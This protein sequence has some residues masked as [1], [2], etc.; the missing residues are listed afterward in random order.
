M[1]ATIDEVESPQS[2]LDNCQK[3]IDVNSDFIQLN[4]GQ[5]L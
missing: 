2:M 3:V 1:S 5:S 4:K